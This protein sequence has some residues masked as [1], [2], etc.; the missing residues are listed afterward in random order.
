MKNKT[1]RTI[2]IAAAVVFLVA[3]VGFGAAVWLFTRSFSI[4]Q[5]DEASA[6]ARFDE[7]RGSFAG[8]TPVIHIQD[9][10]RATLTRR[11]PAE[12]QATRLS[13]LH[14]VAWDPHDRGLARVDLPFA[15]LRLKSGPIEIASEAGFDGDLNLT[16]ED[17]ERYGST[18][19]LDHTARDGERVLVWT[20]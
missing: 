12:R 8:V 3:I 15:L 4:T 11:P 6:L 13:T 2:A 20:Q 19:V 18:L 17:L 16:V 7:V 9:D 10:G 1:V 14:V 5:V